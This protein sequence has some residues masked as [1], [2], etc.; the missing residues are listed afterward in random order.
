MIQV[1]KA[2]ENNQRKWKTVSLIFILLTISFVMILVV[3]SAMHEREAHQVLTCAEAV[4]D[5]EKILAK[6]LSAWEDRSCYDGT[7]ACVD[8]DGD[9]DKEIVLQENIGMSGGAGQYLSRI[10]DFKD[11]EI[12]EIFSFVEN[13]EIF[14]TG[15][16]LTLLKDKE[17]AIAQNS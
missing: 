16:S 8:L 4:F 12:I 5:A 7:F 15:F 17:N 13:E 11:G 9:A 1:M 14:D 3:F 2:S 10:F 6:D